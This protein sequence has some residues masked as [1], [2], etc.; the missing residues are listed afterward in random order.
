MSLSAMFELFG[1]SPVCD[2]LLY[3]LFC[4]IHLFSNSL[5]SV[6]RPCLELARHPLL[7]KKCGGVFCCGGVV[8][9]LW[10]FFFPVFFVVVVW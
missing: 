2:T 9:F 1:Q 4:S 6:D 8:V 7:K 3:F 5:R 10:C